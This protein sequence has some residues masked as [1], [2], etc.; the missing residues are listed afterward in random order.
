MV[1]NIA[2]HFF[3]EKSE[4]SEEI[5]WS[6]LNFQWQQTTNS[7]Y[8]S[9]TVSTNRFRSR[10]GS[11]S[12]SRATVM[13]HIVRHL[14]NHNW[15][16]RAICV[17]IS[18]R[19]KQIVILLILVIKNINLFN[20]F[21]TYRMY[22]VAITRQINIID[23]GWSPDHDSIVTSEINLLLTVYWNNSVVISWWK[24]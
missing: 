10:L 22:Y 13:K 11:H 14:I 15:I 1:Y 3:L 16:G 8:Y 23:T 18:Y 12:D 17:L 20:I 21:W 7:I 24:M 9:I 5:T 19:N 4:C 2:S 6:L